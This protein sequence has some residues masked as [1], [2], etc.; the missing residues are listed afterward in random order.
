MMDGAWE[1]RTAG[2]NARSCTLGLAPISMFSKAFTSK[3]SLHKQCWQFC[4]DPNWAWNCRGNRGKSD[5]GD[6]IFPTCNGYGCRRWSPTGRFSAEVV[7]RLWFN[8]AVEIKVALLKTQSLAPTQCLSSGSH[9]SCSDEVWRSYDLCFD[10]KQPSALVL[11]PWKI[12]AAN[13]TSRA[14]CL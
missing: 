8:A 10:T 11:G 7:S 6:I 13:E 12:W 3:I 2:L 14:P 1:G 5:H 9:I 4:N